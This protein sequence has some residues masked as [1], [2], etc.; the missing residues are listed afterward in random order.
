M[1]RATSWALFKGISEGDICVVASWASPHTFIIFCHLDV[2][3]PPMAHA[4]LDFGS[5]EN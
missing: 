2:T 5:L 4:V 3:A 1:G